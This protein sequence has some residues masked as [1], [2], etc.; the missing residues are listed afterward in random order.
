MNQWE[1][2]IKDTG[3]KVTRELY[4]FR[5]THTGDTE[6]LQPDGIIKTIKTGEAVSDIKPLI[7]LE[8]EMLQSLADELSQKGYKPQKGY[9][10]GKLQ[11]TENHL[12]DMRKLLKLK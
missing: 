1:I 3:Y 11:A 2:T 8:P 6:V 9:L 5:R 7:E 10:E 12:A 4:I